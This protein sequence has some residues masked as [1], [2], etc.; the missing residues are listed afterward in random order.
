MSQS[1]KGGHNFGTRGALYFSPDSSTLLYVTFDVSDIQT[2]QY[3]VYPDKLKA[4]SPDE[5]D[6][7]SFEQY[8]RI[9]E[10]KYA[11]TADKISKTKFYITQTVSKQA[12]FKTTELNKVGEPDSID[13]SIGTG[14]EKSQE[15]RYFS[16][17]S[18]AENSEWFVMTWLSRAATQAKSLACNVDK[19][20]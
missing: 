13:F 11:K 6:Q 8:P 20:S 15:N 19:V 2:L 7:K 5:V 9:N 10:I 14:I 12:D 1:L 17:L 4:P 18:W 16:R 3:S